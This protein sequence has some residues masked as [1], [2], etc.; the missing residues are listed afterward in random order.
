[1]LDGSRYGDAVTQIRASEKDTRES[2]ITSAELPHQFRNRGPG[3]VVP[4]LRCRACPT[5]MAVGCTGV[6]TATMQ[7]G[8]C[9]QSVGW[10]VGE[11]A[12]AGARMGTPRCGG[13]DGVTAGRAAWR[14]PAR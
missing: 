1:M 7:S 4:V 13:G 5:M 6:A 2:V 3:E 8:R 14:N 9:A 11:G 12:R 10:P